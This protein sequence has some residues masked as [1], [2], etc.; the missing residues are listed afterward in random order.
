MNTATW[1]RPV[2]VAELRRAWHAVQDGQFRGRPAT[3]RTKAEPRASGD[4]DATWTPAT[5]E[6]VHLV[7]GC[8]GQVGASTVALAM[9]GAVD[10]PARLVECASLPMSGLV[11]ASDAEL[12]LHPSG[13]LR[14]TRG[15][16]AVQRRSD[17]GGD[18]RV[19]APME[20]D[21]PGATVLDAGM[22][23]PLTRGAGWLATA[24]QSATHLVVVGRMSVPGLRR[25]EGCVDL[26][27]VGRVV[28]AVV[29]P[30]RRGWPRSVACTAG[31]LTRQ[32]LESGRLVCVPED[33]RLRMSGITSEDLPRPV[34][35]A[36]R[37]LLNLMEGSD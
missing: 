14:G 6:D 27:G 21:A 2:S 28:A 37:G 26:L 12:G 3:L 20:A 9:A 13:W 30:A 25:L 7:L 15:D 19:P 10:G 11:M 22:V 34:L 23:W 29:G 17:H 18:H 5:G 8:A 33:W 35:A 36:G 32:L 4:P 1:Q 31:P 16:L 24:A